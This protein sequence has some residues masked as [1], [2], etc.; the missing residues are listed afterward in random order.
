MR[1]SRTGRKFSLGCRL[2]LLLLA[3]LPATLF[4]GEPRLEVI[5]FSSRALRNN[6]LHDPAV[7]SVAVFLP[8]QSTNGARLPVVYYL[9]GFGN[10]SESFIRN[11][12]AW[13][14]LTQKLADEITPML[15]VVVDGR[16][17]WSG[18]QYLNSTAQGNY[19]DYVCE[20]IV[21]QVESRHPATAQGVHLSLIHI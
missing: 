4:A 3:C 20:E 19:A 13:L 16:T 5:E 11:S 12:N 21:S 14:K 2:A 18:S 17:R 15:L 7:R 6:P 1:T 8:A 9:P 10:S